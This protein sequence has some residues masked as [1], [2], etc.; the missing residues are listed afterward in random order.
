[1]Y[2]WI[3][4]VTQRVVLL[5]YS[6]SMKIWFD[7]SNL[8]L[9]VVFQA[10]DRFYITIYVHDLG[11]YRPARYLVDTTVLILEIE[12]KV[13]NM[14]QIIGSWEL[15]PHLIPTRSCWHMKLQ[16]TRFLHGSR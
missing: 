6:I 16:L 12:F 11:T 7:I 3:S 8:D 9:Y 14:G 4:T 1:M 10:T 2:I 13:T 5:T 15:R